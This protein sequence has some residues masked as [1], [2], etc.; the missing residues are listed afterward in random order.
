MTT[1]ACTQLAWV[2][3]VL[4]HV[5]KMQISAI[6]VVGKGKTNKRNIQTKLHRE[7]RRLGTQTCPNRTLALVCDRHDVENAVSAR[8]L[9]TQRVA[10]FKSHTAGVVQ[11]WISESVGGQIGH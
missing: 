1:N 4:L 2:E 10:V 9:E 8:I 6:L 3:G 7:R 5:K 11:Q